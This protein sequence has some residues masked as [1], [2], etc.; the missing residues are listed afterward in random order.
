M[1]TAPG[2]AARRER[3]WKALPAPC[4]VLVIADPQH[5][6]YLANFAIS[7]FEFR[8]NDAT[9]VLVLTPDRATLIGDNVLGPYLEHSFVD[10][11]IAPIWYEGQRTAGGRREGVA[12]AVAELIDQVKPDRIGVESAAVPLSCLGRSASRAETIEV[13]PVLRELRRF[14]DS[15]ELS[16]IR[17]ALAA[18]DAGFAAGLAEIRPGMTEVDAFQVV[19]RAVTEAAGEP[20]RLYGDFVSGPRCEQVGGPPSS[21]TIQRGELVLL[22]F[23]VVLHGYRGD[24]ANTFVAGRGEPNARQAD[25]F[26]ACLDALAAG[27]ATLR[28]GVAARVVD[29]AVRGSFADRGLAATFPSHSGHGVGLGHPEA[30]FLVPRSDDTLAAGDVVTLEPGQYVAGVA[31]M[32]FERNYLITENGYETLSQHDLRMS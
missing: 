17:R 22:D 12:H 1:L 23:S 11:A 8:A 3:L 2:C 5:L 21:R 30:P 7:P 19:Q 28:P 6:I 26:A 9:A 29:A 10:Q 24:C 25:L 27:E 15:D 18:S 13:A 4:D 32:R 16:L 14:K 31:G 20:V